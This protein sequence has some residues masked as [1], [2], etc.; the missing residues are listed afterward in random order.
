MNKPDVA[1]KFAKHSKKEAIEGSLGDVFAVQQP[2]DGCQV[3]KLVHQVNPVMG[4]SPDQVPHDQIAATFPDKERAA[5]FAN[6]LYMEY[7]QKQEALEEKK[8]K[9]TEKL[10][11]A[12][13]MLEKKRSSHMDMIKEN[14]MVAGKSKNEVANLTQ[15]IDELMMKLEMIEASKKQLDNKDNKKKGKEIKNKH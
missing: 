1:K 6:G 5:S 4:M 14:P 13:S 9:V 2:Y 8:M 15:K 7:C 12:M 11:K 3:G 10:K